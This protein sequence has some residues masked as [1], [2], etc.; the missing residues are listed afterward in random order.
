MATVITEECINCGAC[1][2]ECPNTAIYQGG[3]E[4]EMNGATH[5]PIS[6]DIFYI[7]PQ[8]C[9][10]CVGFFDHEACAAVCPV[11]CCVPDPKIPE[12]EEQ[13]IARARELH[14][15][16]TFPPEFPSRFR[17]GD[18]AAAT[19]AA[20]PAV[21]AAPAAASVA[22]APAAPKPPRIERRF[23]GELSED[24]EELLDRLQRPTGGTTSF[25]LGFLGVLTMPILGALPHGTKQKLEDAFGNRALF[26]AAGATACNVVLNFLFY[27][28]LL[29]VVGA[30]VFGG[31]M[32]SLEF[33]SWFFYGV[34]L[35]S[36]ET[37]WRLR[38]GLFH[39]AAPGEMTLGPAFYGLFL[40]P[41]AVPFTRVA[42]R[43]R[44]SGTIAFDG[45]YDG[46][47]DEKRDRERRYGEVYRLEDIGRGYL[48]RLE[49]PQRVPAS[50]LKAELDVPDEMPDYDFELLLSNG[51]FEVRGTVSDPLVRKIASGAPSFPPEFTTR[52]DLVAPVS[53]FRHRYQDK[54]LEVILVKR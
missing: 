39:G 22:P 1:E 24:F 35:A 45:Y 5:A 40:L 25:L 44:T 17:K 10:E 31:D 47:F 53:G 23:A 13:L 8:K 28:A 9:T 54:T 46:Q 52:I 18:G 36:I 34:V 29:A 33:E 20:A 15:E 37:A 43:V 49:F 26:S 30:V 38:D 27:P 3:V 12:T 32:F 6:N 50:S 19:P 41:L 21:T 4:W 51:S 16:V 48:L 42:S 14:P 2:P 11:D 7:V